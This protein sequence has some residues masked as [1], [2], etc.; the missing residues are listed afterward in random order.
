MVDEMLDIKA[1]DILLQSKLDSQY[2]DE[3]TLFDIENMHLQRLP[4]YITTKLQ[5]IL[6]IV[7]FYFALSILIR[8]ADNCLMV[9]NHVN[10]QSIGKKHNRCRRLF[11][12]MYIDIF[13]SFNDFLCSIGFL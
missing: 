6:L 13:E 4:L 2:A 7:D 8:I 1:R 5:S 10:M 9:I 3:V 12:I 11:C